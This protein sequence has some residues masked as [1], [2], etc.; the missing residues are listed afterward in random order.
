[1]KS[2][3]MDWITRAELT[4]DLGNFHVQMVNATSS[5][6]R[7][8]P[9]W[10]SYFS[11]L[12]RVV[13]S[14]SADPKT[15]VGCVLVDDKHRIISTGYNGLIPGQDD[16]LIDWSNRQLVRERV[17]HAEQNC[18]LFAGSRFTNA[19]LYSTHSPCSNC[20]KH[21]AAAG[22]K[23]IFISTQ[24]LSDEELKDLSNFYSVEIKRV[25]HE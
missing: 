5:K 25:S 10:D 22:V 2:Q 6:P 9:S 7:I 14:R 11:Q 8:R 13:A 16:N 15:Q 20:T 23:N 21:L 19:T 4:N 17:I 12:A 24:Y 18:L 1:M 3:S